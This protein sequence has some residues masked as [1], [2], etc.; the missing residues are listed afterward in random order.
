MNI[1]KLF[2]L[3]IGLLA[4]AN[5]D[6]A[7]ADRR[8]VMPSAEADRELDIGAAVDTALRDNP[9]LAE[10]M[11]R[12]SAMAA[13]PSQLG[14]LPDPEI[15]FSAL[16]LP[17]DSFALQ[18]EAMTQL[19]FGISQTV[20]FPGKLGLMEA[21]ATHEA[22]A[23]ARDVDEARLRLVRDVRSEWWTLAY[24]RQAQA[25][26]NQNQDLLRDLI[27]VARTKYSVGQ[28][29]QQDVLLAQLELSKLLDLDLQLQGMRTSE[30]GRLNALLNRQASAPLHL[31]AKID[32]SLPDLPST[33]ALYASAVEVRPR[34]AEQ[35]SQ[36]EAARSRLDLARKDLYPDFNLGASY[37][38]RSGDNPNGSG[39][40]DLL[41]FRVGIKVP[42]FAGRKQ[43][44]AIDQ[45]NS[46]LMQ[47]TYALQDERVQVLSEITSA[48][49]DY[50]RAREQVSL[51][52]SGIIPQ[53]RQTVASMF[54]GYQVSK[55]DFL[56]LVR[57]QLTLYNYQIQYWRSLA[58]ANQA[59]ARL[60][61]AVGKENFHE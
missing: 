22:E 36:I 39:R 11:A 23:A 56:N 53:A 13:I 50:R 51:Y 19:Q 6:T 58:D 12:A 14:T 57:A 34:L 15:S 54:A 4:L 5:L 42:L 37:G 3:V 35:R 31:P 17:V 2:T 1:G 45:R 16:S 10:I 24:L 40:A 8:A 9:G 38:V 7:Y 61:A 30:R 28:G 49:A 52:D 26:V 29:L 60:Y 41:S 25:I 43:S 48:L 27:K 32:L 44:K 47:Q 21:A 20:P 33:A 55:V 46:E 59:L 18:Q